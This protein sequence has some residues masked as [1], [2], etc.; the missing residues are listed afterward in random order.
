MDTMRDRFVKVASELIETDQRSALVLAD[1]SSALF[2]QTGLFS[3]HPERVI[4]VGIREQ[5]LVSFAAGMALEGFRPIV[6]TYAPFLIERPFEQLK[7]DFGHQGVEGVFVSIGASYDAAA[8]GR[9]H[10][11]P[12]DVALVAT[13]PEWTVFVPGHPDEAERVLRHASVYKG[14]VYVRLSDETNS[15]SVAAKPGGMAKIRV[16]KRS[17]FTVVSIG[18]TLDGVLDAT[19]GMECTV[20]YS[21]TPLPFDGKAIREAIHEPNVVI[22]EPYLAGTSAA[23]VSAALWDMPHRLLNI[24]V[25][26]GE[27]RH[28]GTHEEHRAAHGLDAPGIRRQILEFVGTNGPKVGDG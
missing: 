14:C 2:R 24:G 22:V 4:N 21:Y 23:A 3:S 18:P 13:L 15:D 12:E 5:L 7:L 16:S 10:Q 9:T 26:V 28:Y 25:P 27:H 19:E 6:H 11:A 17:R 20:L 8:A 1:I